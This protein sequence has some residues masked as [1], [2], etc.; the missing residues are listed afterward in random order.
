MVVIRIMMTV[1]NTVEHVRVLQC[2]SNQYRWFGVPVKGSQ[3][4]L[5]AIVCAWMIIQELQAKHSVLVRI[6]M[7]WVLVNTSGKSH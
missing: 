2:T 7:V 4:I 6:W 3:A 5:S 1:S